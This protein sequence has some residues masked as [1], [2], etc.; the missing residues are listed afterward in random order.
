[1]TWFDTILCSLE[2]LVVEYRAWALVQQY[3]GRVEAIDHEVGQLIRKQFEGR[4]FLGRV[5]FFDGDPA[6]RKCYQIVYEDGDH[7][8]LTAAEVRKLTY[9]LR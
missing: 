1:M 6:E 2:D 8:A 3:H 5:S 7:D 4:W 9:K